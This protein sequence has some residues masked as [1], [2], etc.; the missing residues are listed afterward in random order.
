MSEQSWWVKH[1]NAAEAA[2]SQFYNG[3]LAPVIKKVAEQSG[4]TVEAALL[5]AGKA[6]ATAAQNGTAHGSQEMIGIA[7]DSLKA[8]APHLTATVSTA[9]A[10]SV[11]EQAHEAAAQSGEDPGLPAS[12][13]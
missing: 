2:L 9:L 3:F 7:L 12:E 6:V 13:K 10:A 5:N 11:V 8:D 4:P 1:R